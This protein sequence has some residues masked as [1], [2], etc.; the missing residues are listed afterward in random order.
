[1]LSAEEAKEL[2]SVIGVVTVRHCSRTAPSLCVVIDE[3]R[4]AAKWGRSVTMNIVRPQGPS[5]PA[6][7][8]IEGAKGEH[9]SLET[10]RCRSLVEEDS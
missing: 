8:E 10:W 6:P 4:W 1:M 7:A 5:F 3:E 2:T 9:R